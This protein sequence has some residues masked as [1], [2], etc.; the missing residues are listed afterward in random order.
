M[1]GLP[2]VG[3]P[4]DGPVRI[5]TVGRIGP[6]KD[7]ALAARVGLAIADLMGPVELTLLGDIVNPR[8]A[9]Q[10]MAMA[11]HD[12]RIVQLRLS[13]EEVV[14]FLSKQHLVLH[15]SPIESLPLVLFEANAAGV[16]FF[17]LPVGG[18]P[19]VLPPPFLLPSEPIRAA[20]QIARMISVKSSEP[21][22]LGP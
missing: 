9:S 14:P 7:P 2:H 17:A 13:H 4:V 3:A 20:H 10:V 15:T 12:L 19:E 22:P 18:I 6:D 11:R 1:Q 21:V 5:A 16:P 8:Y